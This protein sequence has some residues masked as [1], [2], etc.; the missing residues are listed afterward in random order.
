MSNTLRVKR[1]ASGAAGAPASLKS[2]E[3]AYNMVDGVLYVGYGDDGAGNATSIKSFAKD[4]FNP[5]TVYQ[6]QD[7]DLDALAALAATGGILARTG[8][9]AFAVRTIAGTAG[10]IGVTNGDGVAG[11]PT[12]DLA[13]VNPGSAVG[14]GYTKFT[15]DNYGRVTNAGQAAL[16]DLAAAAADVSLGNNKLTNVANPVSASDAANKAYVDNAIQGLDSKASVLAAA[17]ANQALSGGAAF[18]TVDGI[19]TT[20]GD[21]V[22]LMNQTTAS[23]NGIY[24]VGGIATAWTLTR[25]A[26]ADTWA[27][28]P[29]AYCFI[30]RGAT[31][32]DKGYVC[33]VDQGGTLETTAIAFTQFNGAGSVVAGNGLTLTGNTLDV[34]AGT[35]IAVAADSVGLTGQAL[36]LHNVVTAADSLIYGTGAGAFATTTLSAFIRTLLDDADAATARGTLG[37][38]AQNTRLDNVA[39]A[40]ITTA[41]NVLLFGATNAVAVYALGATGKSVMGAGTQAAGQAALGLGSMATQGAGAVAITGGTIDG[42]TLDGGTF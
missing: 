8:A 10:R 14:G 4:T 35:G 31:Y 25:S 6:T 21:R 23:Q 32:G 1:R 38:Q 39:A 34:G 37:A 24:V 28:L 36:A 41:D 3:L 11:A 19:A 18:P 26:D 15:V 12:F 16:S 29:G 20:A 5:S 30:E 9:G 27:E 13:L 42:I 2:G 17:T 7:A 33:T 40:N 22:L